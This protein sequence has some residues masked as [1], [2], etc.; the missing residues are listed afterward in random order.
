[1]KFIMNAEQYSRKRW[2][3]LL[4]KRREQGEVGQRMADIRAKEHRIFVI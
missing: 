1:M 3:G 2:F 4:V